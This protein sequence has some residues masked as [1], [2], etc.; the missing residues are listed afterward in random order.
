M[1]RASGLLVVVLGAGACGS[2]AEASM[3]RRQTFCLNLADGHEDFEAAVDLATDEV[4]SLPEQGPQRTEGCWVA[5]SR[6]ESAFEFLRGLDL[7]SVWMFP[8]EE[9]PRHARAHETGA[10]VGGRLLAGLGFHGREWANSCARGWTVPQDET[11]P[12]T[13]RES[14]A[15]RLASERALCEE[16]AQ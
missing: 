5:A 11:E 12:A 6:V 1:H 15:Q 7:A 4:A 14:T 10:G 3:A 2:H 16:L 13:L 9:D 8:I